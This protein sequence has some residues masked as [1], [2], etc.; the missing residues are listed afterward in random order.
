L[1]TFKNPDRAKSRVKTPT[2]RAWQNRVGTKTRFKTPT[3]PKTGRMGH[4]QNPEI[5]R[6]TSLERA[7]R[8]IIYR[9]GRFR[10]A[11]AE[12]PHSKVFCATKI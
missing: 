4:P 3:L 6:G 1:N 10:K 11:A 9:S 5:H 12:P 2:S 7:S 8:R